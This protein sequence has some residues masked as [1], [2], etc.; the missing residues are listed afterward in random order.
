MSKVKGL[1]VVFTSP[2]LEEQAEAIAQAIQLMSGVANVELSTDK[3]E[4][5]MNRSIIRAGIKQKL[6]G[7][8]QEL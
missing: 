3:A 8:I 5:V 2:V 1:T 4:D 6:L 7:V